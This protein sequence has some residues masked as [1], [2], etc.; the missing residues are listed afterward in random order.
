MKSKFLYCIL[1]FF[2]LYGN[3][4]FSQI[5]HTS[6]VANPLSLKTRKSGPYI[7]FQKGKYNLFEF[8]G[9]VQFKKIKLVHPSIH[10][11]RLGT[12][13]DVIENALGFDGAYWFKHSRFGLTYGGVLSYR[14]DFTY[15]GVAIAPLIGFKLT[16]FH[17][18]VGYNFVDPN[19]K[20]IPMN[21]FFIALK[22]TFIT[23]R[24]RDS[25]L[26]DLKK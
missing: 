23:K 5:V 7:G 9:E 25:A 26:P 13:Y 17:L 21:R 24:K 14:T 22:F 10:A 20:F 15:S 18:Q 12:T 1:T 3:A 19:S 4:A 8:G 2:L 6:S 16:Q 11:F